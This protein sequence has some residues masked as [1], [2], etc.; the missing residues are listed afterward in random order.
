MPAYRPVRHRSRKNPTGC[1]SGVYSQ[2]NNV[3]QLNMPTNSWFQMFK[4][5]KRRIGTW[6]VLICFY[7]FRGHELKFVTDVLIDKATNSIIVADV[8]NRRVS[9]WPLNHHPMRN[10]ILLDNIASC[11]LAMD[12]QKYL[13]VSDV[14]KHEVRRFRIGNKNGTIV[15]G[16]NGKGDGN[17]QLN[18]PTF[19]FV[20]AEQ[21]VYVSDRENHRVIKWEKDAVAGIVVAGGQGQGKWLNAIVSSYGNLRHFVQDC[22]CGR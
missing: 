12:D 2:T 10:D 5:T 4:Q 15:A 18:I 13:Y 11:G 19:L 14:E 7:S 16:G 17:H 20:D 3:S 22:L 9:R 6:N 8:G 21:T 1:I